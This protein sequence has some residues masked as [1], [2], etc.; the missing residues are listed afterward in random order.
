MLGCEPAS[1]RCNRLWMLQCETGILEQ[2]G[3]QSSAR[4][5]DLLAELLE[6]PPEDR[7]DVLHELLGSLE[8]RAVDEDVDVDV[9][10]DV[11][12]KWMVEVR[13]RYQE[14]L[15]GT[16]RLTSWDKVRRRLLGG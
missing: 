11:E 5:Q 3:R 7:L 9:D 13:R 8:D 16:A 10:P 2:M 14:V 6:L 4:K 15:D 1:R 12:A